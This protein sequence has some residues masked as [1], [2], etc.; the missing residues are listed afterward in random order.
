MIASKRLP[1]IL[2]WL[3]KYDQIDNSTGCAYDFVRIP[4]LRPDPQSVNQVVV[5]LSQ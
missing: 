2:F 5:N 3:D 1:E 4:F